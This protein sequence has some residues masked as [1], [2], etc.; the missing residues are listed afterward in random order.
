MLIDNYHTDHRVIA[1]N[2]NDWYLQINED[3]MKALINDYETGAQI[4]VEFVYGVCPT[5]NG[6]GSHVNPSID[7]N[8]ISGND[9]YEDPDFAESYMQ[10]LYDVGCY[11]CHGKRVVPTC[12]DQRVID[13]MIEE[14]NY[15]AECAAE[16]RMGA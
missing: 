1:G 11:E 7:C 3:K 4:W 14:A 6:K 16:R 8:G 2:S 12:D 13:S 9:F 15:Q 10:G 5:C